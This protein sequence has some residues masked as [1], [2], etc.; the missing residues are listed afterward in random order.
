ME[1]SEGGLGK[2]FDRSLKSVG[3]PNAFESI[4]LHFQLIVA[5]NLCRL[6]GLMLTE[7]YFGTLNDFSILEFSSDRMSSFSRWRVAS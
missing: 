4:E 6:Y 7:H 5:R 2:Q 1:S 3:A